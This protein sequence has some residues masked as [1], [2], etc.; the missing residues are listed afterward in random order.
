MKVKL[1]FIA[2]LC[3]FLCVEISYGRTTEDLT[4]IG[5]DEAVCNAESGI[6]IIDV[7]Y[8]YHIENNQSTGRYWSE[9]SFFIEFRIGDCES[10]EVEVQGNDPNHSTVRFPIEIDES[11]G[12]YLLTLDDVTNEFVFTFIYKLRNEDEFVRDDNHKLRAADYLSK[13][14]Y[15]LIYGHA[16]IEMRGNEQQPDT[17]VFDVLGRRVSSTVP[18]GVYI[19]GG[20]KFVAK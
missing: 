3:A 18:G 20:K 17:P 19:R 5:I 8:D 16:G 12:N 13:E 10:C 9:G 15:N 1:N 2:F 7:K 11:T 6:D 4:V 14:D